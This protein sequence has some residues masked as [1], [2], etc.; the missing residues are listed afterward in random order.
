MIDLYAAGTSNGMRGR[1]ALEECGLPY[2]LHPIDLAKG[3]NRTPQFLALNPVGQIP[4]MVDPEGPGGKPVTLAQSTAI[5]MYAAEKSGKFQPK[6]PAARPAFLQA[7]MSASTDVTPGIGA[8]FTVIRSKEP[9]APTAELLKGRL[10]AYFKAWDAELG[11]HKYA[12][13]NEVTIADFSLYAGYVRAMGVIP[14]TCDGMPTLARWGSEMAARPAI[15][16]ATK[17]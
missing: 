6:D 8:V 15:V 3:E 2:K 13:G 10:S 12:A 17:F 7:L 1:I 4:V 16:R 5:L 11:K 14:E 9:H